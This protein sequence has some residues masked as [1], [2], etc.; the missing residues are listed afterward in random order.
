M[1]PAVISR[2]AGLRAAATASSRSRISA[3]APEPWPF[4]SLRSSS[5][6]MNSRERI[7]SG[8]RA[9]P[10]HRLSPAHGNQLVTL[11]EGFVHEF[12]DTD[13]GPRAAVP[14]CDNLGGDA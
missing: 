8:I 7:G 1:K 9:P 13:V 11:V 3:S 6:G 12:D 2:A 5:P 4:A 14:P 10:H